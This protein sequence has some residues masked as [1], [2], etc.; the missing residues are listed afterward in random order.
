MSSNTV[1]EIPTIDFDHVGPCGV[2]VVIGK[3]ASGVSTLIADFMNNMNQRYQYEEGFAFTGSNEHVERMSGYIP[4]NAIQSPINL[5]EIKSM[6][7]NSLEEEKHGTS[8]NRFLIFAD[9]L[10]KNFYKEPLIQNLVI[11][12]KSYGF[13]VIFADQSPV[14][15]SSVIAQPHHVF[16][17]R[18]DYKISKIKLHKFF[19]MFSS[20]DHFDCVFESATKDWGSLYVDRRKGDA[21]FS[22]CV[23]RHKAIFPI[24]DFKIG[25]LEWIEKQ[26][27]EW[28]QKEKEIKRSFI[29]TLKR[30]HGNESCEEKSFKIARME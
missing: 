25:S 27:S 17:L 30:K 1:S 19:G 5:D 15:V 16:A 6:I 8:K 2:V 13:L 7:E 24:P 23:K 28:L 10:D 20:Y 14:I 3:R 26:E 12:A 29:A 18:D 22:E 21:K 4:R 9:L 11:N